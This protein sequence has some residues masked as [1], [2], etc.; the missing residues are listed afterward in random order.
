MSGPLSGIKVLDLTRVLAG[1]FCTMLLCDLGATV[2]KVERPVTGD[3]SRGFGPMVNGESAYFMSINRGK[4]GI[5][6]NLKRARGREILLELAAR[7]DVLVENFRPGTMERL[8]LRY[9]RFKEK[10]PVLIYASSSGFGHTG[11]LKDRTAYDIV[12]QG[13]SGMMSITGPD[14]ENQSKVGS[15]IAD[16][17]CGIFTALAITAALNNR[18]ETGRGQ[19]I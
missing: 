19:Y 16:I 10:N 11:P 18:R 15:S 2:I 1:P 9:E 6:L 3:D 7:S 5:T 17:L 4:K 13:M 12:I 14:V 8:G